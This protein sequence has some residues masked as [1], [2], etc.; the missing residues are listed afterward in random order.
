MQ[1]LYLDSTTCD[2]LEHE[3]T[4]PATNWWTSEKMKMREK[5]ELSLGGF[6]L[7]ELKE[8]YSEGERNTNT[9]GAKKKTVTVLTIVYYLNTIIHNES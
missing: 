7:G 5:Q 6:G 2:G 1:L 9:C 3:R 4:S 8:A